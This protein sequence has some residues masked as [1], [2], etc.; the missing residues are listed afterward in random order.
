MYS[1]Q[2]PPQVRHRTLPVQLAAAQHVLPGASVVSWLFVHEGDQTMAHGA[3]P[4]LL[5][6]RWL[7]P[8][9]IA[10][11]GD[12]VDNLSLRTVPQN[13]RQV[14]SVVYS[15]K[16]TRSVTQITRSSISTKVHTFVYR[17]DDYAFY[18]AYHSDLLSCGS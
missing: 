2:H 16:Y 6:P 13:I 10:S 4:V 18:C 15:P 8:G 3:R 7:A 1:L 17:S 14:I 11:V 12:R 9:W 5:H